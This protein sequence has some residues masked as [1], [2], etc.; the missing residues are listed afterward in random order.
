MKENQPRRNSAKVLPLAVFFT[1]VF[2]IALTTRA[3]PAQSADIVVYKSPTCDCCKNWVAHMQR[4]GHSVK[5]QNLDDLDMIKKMAGV[6]EP[7]QS[8]HTAM[9]DGYVVE[10]HVPAKDVERLLTERPKARGI[11][12]PGMPAGSPGMGGQAEPYNVMLFQPDGSSS[13]YAR[14]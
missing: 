11:A 14:Y 5:T 9:V 1:F 4:N 13:V 6:P 8:C 12:V 3:A 2:A 7:L 10:G